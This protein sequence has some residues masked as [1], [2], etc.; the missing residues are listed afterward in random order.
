M[1][2]GIETPTNFFYELHCWSNDKEILVGGIPPDMYFG[3]I[4][5]HNLREVVKT[6]WPHD[7]SFLVWGSLFPT[8]TK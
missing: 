8:P 5:P 4:H 6:T 1:E 3:G 2:E 7:N